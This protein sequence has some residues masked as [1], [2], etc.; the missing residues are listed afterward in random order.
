MNYLLKMVA[1]IMYKKKK[2]E[3]KRRKFFL[4]LTHQILNIISFIKKYRI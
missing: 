2:F 4:Q 1:N 3:E